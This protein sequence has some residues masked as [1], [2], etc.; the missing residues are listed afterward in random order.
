MVI[1]WIA[2]LVFLKGQLIEHVEGSI[3]NPRQLSQL[4]TETQRATAWS[5]PVFLFIPDSG[6]TYQRHPMQLS[7]RAQEWPPYG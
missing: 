2:Q 1:T 6:A 3:G 7:P 4:I 5:D